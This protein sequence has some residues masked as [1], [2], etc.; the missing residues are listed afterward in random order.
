[1]KIRAQNRPPSAPDSGRGGMILREYC[2][3]GAVGLCCSLAALTAT[4]QADSPAALRVGN[5]SNAA[6]G[7]AHPA[8]WKPLTFTNSGAPTRYRLVSERGTVVLQAESH[9]SAS[10]LTREIAIDPSQYPIVQWRW[11]VSNVLEKGDVTRKAGDDSPARLY[12]TFAYDADHAGWLEKAKYRAARWLHGQYPPRGALNYIWANRRPVG[13]IT[14]NPYTHRVRML[15]V[16][17]GSAKVGQWITESRNIH[18]D[19]QAAFGQPPPMISGVAVMTDT[20]NTH[21]SATAW[22]GDIVFTAAR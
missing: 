10:G 12:I 3:R 19:Y 21:E 8:N 6:A 14:P 5:F 4:L 20:D 2:R 22:F 17:S 11:K 15:A 9:D 7:D 1:M 13:T 18:H 16:E